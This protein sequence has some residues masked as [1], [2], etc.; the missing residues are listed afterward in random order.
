MIKP[1]RDSSLCLRVLERY[2]FTAIKNSDIP[3]V[4]QAYN[5]I[6]NDKVQTFN[7]IATLKIDEACVLVL[8][9]VITSYK[10][11]NTKDEDEYDLLTEIIFDT[12][13]IL[14]TIISFQN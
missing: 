7:D 8:K 3:N 11:Q 13:S 6:R 5:L 4:S 14:E 10:Q 12:E 9:E 1:P 2:L